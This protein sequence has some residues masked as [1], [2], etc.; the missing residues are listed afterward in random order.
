M[1]DIFAFDVARLAVKAILTSAAAYPKP[2]LATPLDGGTQGTGP[3]GTGPMDFQTMIGG[4][5]ALLP[6]FLNCASIGFEMAGMGPEDVLGHL[7]AA[8][9]Q[10][11]REAARATGRPGAFRGVL[12]FLGLLCAGV[13]R[14]LAHGR[15][16]NPRALALSASS[17]VRGVAAADQ[18]GAQEEAGRGF[19]VTLN[20][21]ALLRSPELECL[22]PRERLAHVFLSILSQ[23]ADSSLAAGGPD[24]LPTV[25]GMARDALA[26]GGMLTPLGREAV[27]EMERKFRERR[28]S[29]RGGFTV[30]SAAV[31]LLEAQGLSAGPVGV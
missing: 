20:A 28:L 14:L 26:A 17:F 8:G 7:R 22:T 4:A 5:L 29:P 19:P 6:C 10:G 24:G 1:G 16:L 18:G 11:E 9:R 12:F 25:Q 30:L 31:F 2:G 21:A 27:E 23:N 13:G 15:D 3:E